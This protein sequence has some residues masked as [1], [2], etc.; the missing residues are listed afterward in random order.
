MKLVNKIMIV[1][2]IIYTIVVVI[3]GIG[4]NMMNQRLSDLENIFANADYVTI[5]ENG[6][7]EVS[8]GTND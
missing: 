4:L 6:S 7:A 1:I 8:H 2:V 3:L 5:T